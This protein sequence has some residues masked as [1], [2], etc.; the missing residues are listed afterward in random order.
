MSQWILLH[1]HPFQEYREEYFSELNKY[2]FEVEPREMD[3]QDF[4]HLVGAK[5]IDDEN[6]MEYV[7]TRIGVVGKYIVVWRA[8]VVNAQ[9]TI[10]IEEQ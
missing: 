2:D 9:G 4:Q 5:Y 8:P 7:N 3:P 10:G 1:F 6:W